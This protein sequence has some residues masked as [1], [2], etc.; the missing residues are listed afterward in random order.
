LTKCLTAYYFF[1]KSLKIY[2][3]W[4]AW[5]TLWTPLNEGNYYNPNLLVIIAKMSTLSKLRKF[6]R[7]H[8]K[9]P[10]NSQAN[11]H[12]IVSQSTSEK[13]VDKKDLQYNG[14]TL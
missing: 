7:I 3:F 14:F 12:F 1:K 5:L 8:K 9:E 11:E 6:N 2:F 10:S 4:L 13:P